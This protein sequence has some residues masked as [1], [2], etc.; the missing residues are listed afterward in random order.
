MLLVPTFVG[1]STFSGRG[2]FAAR[3][4]KKGTVVWRWDDAVDVVRTA[5]PVREQ[6]YA[7]F[8]NGAWRVPGDDARY[9]KA[10]QRPNLRLTKT[11]EQFAALRH[12]EKGE[13]LS[14]TDD[15]RVAQ[16]TRALG[17]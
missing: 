2:L 11:A 14:Y 16:R 6:P 15:D 1:E 9:L 8:Q 7:R 3:A 10:S 12:I 13:E 4:I 5:L 17:L